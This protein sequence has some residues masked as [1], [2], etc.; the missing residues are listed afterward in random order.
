MGSVRPAT[1]AGDLPQV[2]SDRNKLKIGLPGLM[3]RGAEKHPLG[4]E[5]VLKTRLYSI[6]PAL[7]PF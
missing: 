6:G 2:L 4:P 7:V 1:Q 5:R 3:F